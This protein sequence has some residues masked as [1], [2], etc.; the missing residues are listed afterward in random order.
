MTWEA[1]PEPRGPRRWLVPAIAAVLA[2][3]ATAAAVASRSNDTGQLTIGPSPR[4]EET[5]A[6][7]AP[8]SESLSPRSLDPLAVASEL[9]GDGPLFDGAPPL[10]LVVGHR[11]RLAFVDLASGDI[12]QLRLPQSRRPPPGVAAIFTVGSH[13][14]VNHHETVLRLTPERDG[15]VQITEDRRAIPTFDDDSIWVSEQLMSA[16]ASTVARVTLDGTVLERV[17]L[18]AI[19]RPIAGTADGL[20]VSSPG[21]VSLVNGGGAEEI[22]PSG[23]LV[24]SNGRQMARVDC[25]AAVQKATGAGGTVIKPAEDIPG[26]GRFAILRDPA[27]AV[28]A[29]LKPEPQ[30]V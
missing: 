24:A 6:A 5:A 3:A 15:A 14:I 27:S 20:V 30:A 4:A 22:A 11:E 10:T 9:S 7:T 17:R 21:G 26:V 23:D 16:V 28:F 1:P 25:D 19:S 8:P 12:R 29:V 2:I 13:V 18:P